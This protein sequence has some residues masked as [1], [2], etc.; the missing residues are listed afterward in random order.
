MSHKTNKS[1]IN[2][3]SNT[4]NGVLYFMQKY[5]DK[6]LPVFSFADLSISAI[7]AGVTAIIVAYAVPTAIIFQ[8]AENAHLTDGQIISWIWAY[9]IGSGLISIYASWRTCQPL[10]MA[11]STPGIAFLVFALEGQ[12]FSDAIGAFLVSNLMILCI[13]YMGVFKAM[14]R[15]IPLSVAAALNAGILVPFVLKGIEGWHVEPVIVTAM[16]AAFFIVRFFSHRWAVAAVLCVGILAC[17]IL[18]KADLNTFQFAVAVPI[19]TMPSFNLSTI[20]DIS[21]PLT[22]LALTG[23][24]L[25]GFATLKSFGFHSDNDRI[26]KYCGF[27]SVIFAFFG[28]HNIN[29]SSIVAGIV[30]GPEANDNPSKRYWAAIMAGIVYILFGTFAASFVFLFLS[31]PAQAIM[32][33]AGIALLAAIAQSLSTAFKEETHDVL[34]PTIVFIVAIS[35]LNILGL[36]APFWAIVI[37][38]L[39]SLAK[40]IEKKR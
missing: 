34:T 20:I 25:P 40:R 31:L 12:Q 37:G 19:F 29:P 3:I 32:A 9:S 11:C 16:I 13:G 22:V 6:H 33:L 21:I 2:D 8:V 38:L 5:A 28:C 39:L 30:A 27:V 15:F 1:T 24:Y 14:M 35:N 4:P 7:V 10:I 26:V 23:Q 17:V 18:G 36:N